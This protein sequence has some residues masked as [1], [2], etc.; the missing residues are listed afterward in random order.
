VSYAA[1]NLVPPP[2]AT[3]TSLPGAG[4][5]VNGSMAFDSSGDLWVTDGADVAEY[6]PGATGSA[7]P[8]STF[9]PA[10]TN[11]RSIAIDSTGEILLGDPGAN[12][13]YAYAAG[14]TGSALPIRTISGSSTHLNGGPYRMIVDG[15]DNLWVASAT[16]A[17]IEEFPASANGNVAPSL[18]LDATWA[19]NNGISGINSLAIDASG[20]LLV[21]GN[22][23][24]HVFTFASGVTASSTYTRQITTQQLADIAVDD[25]GYV[26]GA[27]QPPYGV[28]VYPP[29]SSGAPA[30]YATIASP[31]DGLS[32]PI[33]VAVW[34][35][36]S[37]WYGG[38]A[39]HRHSLRKPGHPL[40]RPRN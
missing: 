14:S 40:A 18:Y 23:G 39:R 33:A 6:A 21:L 5:S 29:G 2:A 15:S 37:W 13:I 12:A 24:E 7:I 20:E 38:D 34:S 22:G 9:I 8:L 36:S 27:A 19:S 35:G 25:Q 1:G 16:D 32:D 11:V 26:Y 4:A 17:T 28:L 3:I 31:N 10:D 30:P